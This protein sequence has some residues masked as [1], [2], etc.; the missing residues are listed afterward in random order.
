MPNK[1]VKRKF[2]LLENSYL[3]FKFNKTYKN[4]RSLVSDIYHD[5]FLFGEFYHLYNIL[6]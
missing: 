1:R 2:I 6:D 4:T 3:K 5:N